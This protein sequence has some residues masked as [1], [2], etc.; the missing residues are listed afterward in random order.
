MDSITKDAIA[1]I[2]NEINATED[3]KKLI[4]YSHTAITKDINHSQVI[5]LL[6]LTKQLKQ[7]TENFIETSNKLA[8]AEDK[9]SQRMVTLTWALVIVGVLQAL[10]VLISLFK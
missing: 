7:S 6:I 5:S 3:E 8:E 10:G 1:S 4:D 9:N 2:L